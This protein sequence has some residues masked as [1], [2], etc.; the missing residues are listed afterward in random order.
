MKAGGWVQAQIN[1]MLVSFIECDD[2]STQTHVDTYR[3]NNNTN[4]HVHKPK[5]AFSKTPEIKMKDRET[6]SHSRA[7]EK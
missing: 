5:S 4:R 1:N 3:E 7:T 6:V 2:E